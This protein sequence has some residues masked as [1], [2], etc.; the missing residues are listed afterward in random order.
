[1]RPRR[2]RG[3]CK[4]GARTSVP[5]SESA[6]LGRA[7]R[8]GRVSLLSLTYRASM[9]VV[10]TMARP[11]LR[12]LA[13]PGSSAALVLRR[14]GPFDYFP[15]LEARSRFWVQAVS[16]GEVALARRFTVALV[17]RF[18]NAGAVL[19]SSTPAG[20]RMLKDAFPD[21]SRIGTGPFPF[22]DTR[23]VTRA[24]DA[25]RPVALILL[26]TELWP[27]LIHETAARGIPIAVLNG[28][29][30]ARSERHYRRVVSLMGPTLDLVNVF[31]VQTA[32]TAAR[33]H[34]LGVAPER[35]VVTGSMKYDSVDFQ[36]SEVDQGR[37]LE[38]LGLDSDHGPL[39]VAGS[40]RP[41][42]EEALLTAFCKL[43]SDF[44]NLKL[45]LAPRHLRRMDEVESAIDTL[46]L[47]WRRRSQDSGGDSSAPIIVLDTIGELQSVYSLADVAFVGG[48]LFPG[49]GGHNPLEPA[50][51]GKPVIFGPHMDN[52][53]DIADMLVDAGGATVVADEVEIVDAVR[54]LLADDGLRAAAGVRARDAVHSGQGATARSLDLLAGLLESAGSGC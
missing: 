38:A 34:R 15:S 29:L 35:V 9:W 46:G 33:L 7:L 30:S 11:T 2:K 37:L 49:I 4:N 23:S 1:M 10:T 27:T 43:R 44:P 19:T 5:E 8:E 39:V 18:G 50:A 51:L 41:G 16:V 26:E 45:I 42:E 53:R 6:T 47:A 40:T 14:T 17:D 28:R 52:C 13:R 20:Q 21:E 48:S 25:Y 24:L 36:A 3:R 54:G 32:K 22:D 12:L 31:G